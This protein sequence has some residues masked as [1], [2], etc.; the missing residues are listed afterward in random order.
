[1]TVHPLLSLVFLESDQNYGISGTSRTIMA[2]AR[3]NDWFRFWFP[4]FSNIENLQPG[5]V[6]YWRMQYAIDEDLP[7]GLGHV[8]MYLGD[9][10]IIHAS[11]TAG[12]VV[13][14]NIFGDT[15]SNVDGKLIGY[16]RQ[17]AGE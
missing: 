9:G 2:I 13:M 6:L 16:S 5:D 17:P 3:D 11:P 15:W 1:M 12:R 10:K 4:R 14:T 8:G 7:Y